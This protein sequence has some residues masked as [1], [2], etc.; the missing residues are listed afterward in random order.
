M[1]DVYLDQAG[2]FTCRDCLN[3]HDLD[4]WH[5][6]LKNKDKLCKE[7]FDRYPLIESVEKVK[8]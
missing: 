2:F 1:I 8:A 3:L 4:E 6:V 7:C 5:F